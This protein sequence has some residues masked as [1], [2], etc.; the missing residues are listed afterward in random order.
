MTTTAAADS[1]AVVNSTL[2]KKLSSRL[3][4]VRRANRNS[5]ATSN[6]SAPKK[7]RLRKA[8]ATLS[9]SYQ[10]PTLKLNLSDPKHLADELPEVT[11]QPALNVL[12]KVLGE[13]KDV[14]S[15]TEVQ[16][17]DSGGAARELPA[18]DGTG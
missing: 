10:P 8:A 15:A 14:P 18:T 4:R 13:F 3:R 7:A 2:R 11:D 17:G 9:R 1:V 6:T 16:A 5:T 12:P